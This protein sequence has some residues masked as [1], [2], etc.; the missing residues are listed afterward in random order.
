ML[1]NSR[2]RADDQ[3]CPF[4]QASI[5]LTKL[6]ADILHIGKEPGDDLPHDQTYY[7]MLFSK[8]KPFEEFFCVCI[9]RL[10][11]TWKEMK[12]STSDFNKVK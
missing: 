9:Q 11:K 6:L 1:E 2:E 10:T 7:P 5:E 3:D 12:A 8:E 4:V